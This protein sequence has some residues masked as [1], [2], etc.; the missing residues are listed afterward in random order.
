MNEQLIA[1]KKWYFSLPVKEQRM[2]LFTSALIIVTLFYVLVWEP[3]FAGLEQQQTLLDSRNRTL[4][5]MQQYASQAA[6]LRRS[7]TVHTIRDS[8]KPVSLVVDRSLQNAGLKPRVKKLES[9]SGDE[10]KV[11]LDDAAFN[12]ILVWLNTLATHNGIHV[13]S[14]SIE[15]SDNDGYADARFTLQR[16]Q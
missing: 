12:Q 9:S 1:F 15:R 10:A 14:A 5:E 16:P 2:V 4:L 6:S 7:G 11:T 3:V 8:D 13:V